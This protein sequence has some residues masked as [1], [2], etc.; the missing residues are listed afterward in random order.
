M[1][2]HITT[3]QQWQSAQNEGHYI[4]DSLT[5]EGFIHCSLRHQLIRV[6]NYNFK[7]QKGLVLLVI[8]ETMLESQV[9]YEDLYRSG[10]KF[11][12]VYGPVNLSSVIG[13]HKFSPMVDG[14]FTLPKYV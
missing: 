14:N 6:A 9:K 2:L 7:H 8:D 11:P 4:A 13:V 5:N 12:H 1:L 3:K 10:E